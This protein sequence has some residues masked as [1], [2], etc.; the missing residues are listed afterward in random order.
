MDGIA[1]AASISEM[2]PLLI[3]GLIQQIAQT[4]E[5]GFVLYIYAST[6]QRVL[7]I[8]HR[9]RIHLTSHSLPHPT[10]PSP[11]CML[12][13]KY[14]RYGRIIDITQERYERV[15]RF[16]ITRKVGSN[17]LTYQL[18]GELLGNSGNL[19]LL[20]D[21]EIIDALYR[22][23]TG[24]RPIAP[25][26]RYLP[27]PA[28]L[29]IEPHLLTSQ[30][31]EMIISSGDPIQRLSARVAG[32]NKQTAR[33][34]IIAGNQPGAS[35]FT[36]FQRVMAQ[37]DSP[38]PFYYPADSR[39]SFFPLIENGEGE[40]TSTFAAA[41][42][43]EHAAQE[44]GAREE[45]H[46]ASL[47]SLFT[48]EIERYQRAIEKVE[49]WV[50]EAMQADFLRRRAD[51]IMANLH[52][53]KKGSATTI[54]VDPYSGEEREIEIDPSIKPVEY[55]QRLYRRA[56]KLQRGMRMA[57][58]RLDDLK[59][60]ITLL[61]SGLS[62]LHSDGWPSDEAVLLAE[63]RRQRPQR[64]RNRE[65][66]E[67]APRMY[68]IAGF[69][70]RIGKNAIQNDRLVRQASPDDLWFHARGHPGSHVIISRG[71]KR[72]VPNAVIEAAAKL[73][74]RHSQAEQT[75]KVEV[76]Y[77]KV[78]YLRKPKGAPPGVVILSQ[79]DTLVVRLDDRRR[80]R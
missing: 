36:S 19:I 65:E 49:Q 7:L 23:P 55:A 20:H 41:L 59:Q 16:V 52:R 5:D 51:V 58:A 6:E 57:Q 12:L 35:V 69:I 8:P 78:K 30:E 11:F 61:K 56:G 17:I 73:A 40:E 37:I 33:H 27:L 42:D 67:T 10:S 72:D 44:Q 28:Q 31:T 43:R 39:A 32:I 79:E 3:G 21:E 38:L 76:S 75:G 26:K 54:I 13:R 50:A 24:S 47:I 53:L 64:K 29:K 15:I 25:S 60:K 74:A 62:T 68:N 9:A 45:D 2:R 18:V 22:R 77:T 34:I 80:D 71:N 63:E 14:L 4:G 66:R 46:N 70:V 1:I 48:A